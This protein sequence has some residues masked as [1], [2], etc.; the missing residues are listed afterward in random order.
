MP[1]KIINGE[2]PSVNP[3]PPETPTPTKAELDSLGIRDHQISVSGKPIEVGKAGGRQL[4][5]FRNVVETHQFRQPYLN[6]AEVIKLGI[7]GWWPH[8]G[9]D[10]TTVCGG[11]RYLLSPSTFEDLKNRGLV[12]QVGIHEAEKWRN[13]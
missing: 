4:M 10:F 7:R 13:K 9:T 12:I 8:R 3:T 5:D 6:E 1:K 2:N 11:N